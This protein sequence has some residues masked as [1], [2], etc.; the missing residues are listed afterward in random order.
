MQSN[1]DIT[2]ICNFKICK[3][4]YYCSS[5][6]VMVYPINPKDMFKTLET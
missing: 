3:E 2:Y 6:I 1:M 4:V 5:H